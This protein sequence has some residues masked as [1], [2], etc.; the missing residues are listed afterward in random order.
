LHVARTFQ[1]EGVSGATELDNRP[2]L[3]RLLEALEADKVEVVII[4]KLDRLARDLGVQEAIIADLRKR[5]VTLI[6]VHEPDLCS[7]DPT[8]VL[9]RQIIGAV[10][11]Y[12]KAMIVGKLKGARE[13]MKARQ[14]RCEGTKPFGAFDGESV[15]LS[16]MLYLRKAGHTLETVASM[17]DAEG[18]KPR[19][20]SRWYAA[21][22]GRILKRS[23]SGVS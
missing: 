12:E 3:S 22:V 11:Q 23:A 16:R 5:G 8:R 4:E 2:A 14:G 6:S 20:G 15:T 10:A 18:C 1:E 13:R 7:M 9:M 17:L 19:T 21:S